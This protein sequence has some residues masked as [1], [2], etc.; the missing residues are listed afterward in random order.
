[1]PRQ[2][3]TAA[4]IATVFTLLAAAGGAAAQERPPSSFVSLTPI[5]QGNADLDRGGE[6]RLTGLLTRIGTSTALSRDTRAGITLTYDY[7]DYS[8]S[9]PVAF[10]S[11]APWNKVQR[12]GAAFPLTT[13]VGDGWALGV[14][15]AVDWFLENGA[16]T[17][18][19]LTWGATFSA[20]RLYPGGNRLGLG[21]AAFDRIEDKSLVPFL[22][23]DWRLGERWRLLNPLPSGP[24]GGAGLELDY[25]FDAGWSLGLG[26][27]L[28]EYRF[29]L[30]NS[31]PVSQGIGEERL[32][33]VFLRAT[34]NLTPAL[35][36]YGY[37]GVGTGGRLRV[38]DPAGNLLR[39]DD[40]G[41]APLFGLTLIGRF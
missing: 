5:Y 3:R 30:A 40:L 17:S 4:L 14:A 32:V 20:I 8:S 27:A 16:S 24:T 34:V 35:T 39:Q 38:E 22:I 15:P 21:L 41:N 23:V 33:P 13:R 37:A 18:D 29:R 36:L 6:A 11:V 9:G 31:G 28:R 1:M 12:Y 25:Q 2:Q 26:A 19:A 10:N 7:F